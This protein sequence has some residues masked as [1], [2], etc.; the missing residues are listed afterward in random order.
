MDFASIAVHTIVH[1]LC[2]ICT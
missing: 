2:K 1:F